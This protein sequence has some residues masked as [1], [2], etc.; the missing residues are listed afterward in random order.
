M[1]LAPIAMS[2]LT[3]CKG[4]LGIENGVVSG[5][6]AL[7]DA[8]SDAL[9]DVPPD[10]RTCWGTFQPICPMPVP[11]D[12]YAVSGFT[13]FDTLFQC[14]SIETIGGVEVC[15]KAARVITIAPGTTFQTVGSR[16]LVLVAT[17]QMT[18]GGTLDGW[19]GAASSCN[20]VN[21]TGTGAGGPG[22]SLLVF[23]GDGGASLSA[24]TNPGAVVPAISTFRRGCP[25]GNGGS[26]SPPGG[27]GGAGG[28][29]IFLVS[30][31]IRITSSAR[32]NASGSGGVG[33]D[34]DRGGGGGGSGGVIVFD[35][36]ALTIEAGAIVVALG[37]GGGGGG[38]AGQGIAGTRAGAIMPV[39]PGLGGSG[40]AGASGDGGDATLAIGNDGGTATN[41]RGGGG[42]GGAVGVI[43]TTTTNVMNNGIVMPALLSP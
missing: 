40:N 20:T 29:G 28:S 33:G 26:M 27:S 19:G 25:G 7:V 39:A 10:T 15:V 31:S 35:T 34:N 3:G 12:V 14:P 16:H 8:T 5:D 13:V 43:L 1:R 23:G 11:T 42:G 37:G 36:E 41:G 21:A 30:P 32:I 24:G 4:I 2:V 18:I 9:I 17:E 6:A 38:G 22:G